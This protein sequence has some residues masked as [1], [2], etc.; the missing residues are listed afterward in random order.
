LEQGFALR[1]GHARAVVA[2]A[3]HGLAPAPAGP[4]PAVGARSGGRCPAG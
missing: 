4:L 3:Q 1:R 2:H